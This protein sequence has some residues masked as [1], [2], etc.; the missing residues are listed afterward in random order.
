MLTM[1]KHLRQV[2][3]LTRIG[4]DS[5]FTA[6]PRAIFKNDSLFVVWI[7]HRN[8]VAD[9][10]GTVVVPQTALAVHDA[11]VA[12]GGGFRIIPNPVSR[13]ARVELA[14]AI[15]RERELVL[16]DLSGRQLRQ[17][18]VPAGASEEVI[19]L[20]GLS[21]GTYLLH[22]RGEARGELVVVRE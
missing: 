20:S 3:P 15:S 10:Y 7:D 14:R 9:V 13:R 8:G 2:T 4:G 22:V 18:V 17:F 5:A 1:N 6:T 16:H 12:D 19:D 11:P 21:A